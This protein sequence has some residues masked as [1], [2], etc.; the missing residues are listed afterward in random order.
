MR[1]ELKQPYKSIEALTTEDLPDFA[2]LIGRNGAG[3]TQ[4]LDALKE[5]KATI[6]DIAVDAI[7]E[8]DMVTFRPPNSGEANRHA[9]QFAQMTADAYLLTPPGGQSPIEAAGV[10]FDQIR[11]R[12][13]TGVWCQSTRRLRAQLEGRSPVLARFHCIRGGRPRI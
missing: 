12:D 1:I 7:E 5:G 8:Y 13:R 3:K 4:I 6:A 9:N 11:R 10:I 2:V